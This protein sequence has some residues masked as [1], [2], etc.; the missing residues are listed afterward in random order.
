MSLGR[1][2]FGVLFLAIAAIVFYMILL[3]T[4][5]SNTQAQG[6]DLDCD[7][8]QFQEDAQAELE[9][10]P[11]DPNDLDRDN[12][13]VACEDLP[14]RGGGEGQERNNDLDCADFQDQEEAQAELERDPSDPNN[15]DADNDGIACEA[16]DDNEI[17]DE[18]TNEITVDED[19]DDDNGEITIKDEIR[20]DK[21]R[22]EQSDVIKETIPNKPLPPSGGISVA[23][24]VSIFVLTGTGL[25]GLGVVINRHSRRQ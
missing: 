12:D 11:S 13:G 9:R 18:I 21:P 5:P 19:I 22:R 4:T 1:R 23:L 8:F 14:S 3:S 10:N 7:D 24:L 20:V 6:T 25:L 17:I 16:L 15:L 2:E